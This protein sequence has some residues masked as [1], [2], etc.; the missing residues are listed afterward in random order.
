MTVATSEAKRTI[1]VVEDDEWLRPLLAELLS[2]EGYRV[3]EAGSGLEGLY[4]I[5]QE[6]PDLVVLDVGLP[7]RSGLAV[8]EDLRVQERTRDVP[9][10]LVSGSVDLG[11]TR[12]AKQ[13]AAA[14]HKPLDVEA[15]LAKIRQ[16]VG[17]APVE[18]PA[19]HPAS[20]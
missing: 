1:L 5:H 3:C 4:R 12:Q 10:F 14:F 8:L 17:A 9:V 7:W 11:E 19:S 2:E 18:A 16:A 20:M 15:L 13:A 6:L